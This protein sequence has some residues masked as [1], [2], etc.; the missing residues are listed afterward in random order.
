MAINTY[1]SII[2]LNINGLNVPI[3]RHMV[4]GWIKKQDSPIR[5]L[6]EIH[7]RPKD[8]CR[9]KVRGWRNIYHTNGCQRKARV[10]VFV[11]DK[12][13]FKTET[14]TRQGHYIII[15]ETFNKKI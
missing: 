15:K 10:T 12:I 4:T 7:F 2:T 5:C 13:D 9:L 11:S 3:K 14:V 6:Q 1:P 8:T